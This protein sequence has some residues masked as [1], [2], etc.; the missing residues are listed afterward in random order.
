MVSTAFVAI[1]MVG[2]A[3]RPAVRTFDFFYA[4]D[5]ETAIEIRVYCVFSARSWILI[6]TPY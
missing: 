6:V 4:R 3:E 5:V 2:G 1:D